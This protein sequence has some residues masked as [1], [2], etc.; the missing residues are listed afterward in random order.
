MIRFR[1]L[2]LVFKTL[3]LLPSRH[4][5]VF[6]PRSILLCLSP[7]LYLISCTVSMALSSHPIILQTFREVVFVKIQVANQWQELHWVLSLGFPFLIS[8]LKFLLSLSV[9]SE[10]YEYYFRKREKHYSFHQNISDYVP[11]QI[12]ILSVL[13]LRGHHQLK[14]SLPLTENNV[15]ASAQAQVKLRMLA[16]SALSALAHT[17]SPLPLFTF[18]PSDKDIPVFECTPV[19]PILLR[20]CHLWSFTFQNSGLQYSLSPRSHVFFQESNALHIPS[21]L[22]LLPEGSCSSWRVA[23]VSSS[24][25]PCSELQAWKENILSPA[26]TTTITFKLVKFSCLNCSLTCTFYNWIY[27]VDFLPWNVARWPKFKWLP[28]VADIIIILWHNHHSPHI[29]LIMI[30]S[31]P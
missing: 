4:R 20:T 17:V 6:H 10:I 28:W 30:L 3:H 8:P 11:E 24:H 21:A 15:H 12:S 19:E 7:F 31:A 26:Q 16:G 27:K 25:Q 13:S 18:S 23:A 2:N 1:Y 5:D 22:H 14:Y 29:K 9:T